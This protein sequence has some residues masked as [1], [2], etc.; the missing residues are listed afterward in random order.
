MIVSRQHLFKAVSLEWYVILPWLLVRRDKHWLQ[1]LSHSQSNWCLTGEPTM[2]NCRHLQEP[3]ATS[4]WSQ[5]QQLHERIRVCVTE[6]RASHI[7]VCT[8]FSLSFYAFILSVCICKSI[9]I[10]PIHTTLRQ[11]T[12]RIKFHCSLTYHSLMFPLWT[13]N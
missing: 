13:Y 9:I 3:T 5:L 6:N 12:I 1:S 10:L 4:C 11:N 8:T 7:D 2:A